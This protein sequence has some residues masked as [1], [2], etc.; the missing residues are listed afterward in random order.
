MEAYESSLDG[1]LGN[2][3]LIQDPTNKQK[4]TSFLNGQRDEFR[5]LVK[6][7]D[8]TKDRGV[9]DQMEAIKFSLVN[10]NDQIKVFD[11]DKMEYRTASN[12]N[13]LASIITY[14][15][16]GFFTNAFTNNAEMQ[17]G[18]NGD[19]GFI[20]NNKSYNYRDKAGKWN[21]N[22]NE[23]ETFV[24]KGFNNGIN[25]GS[26]GIKLNPDHVY[27]NMFAGLKRSTASDLQVLATTDFVGDNRS[28]TFQ[29]QFAS[30]DPKFK[31]IYDKI[32]IT[33]GKDGEYDTEW[34]FDNK[35]SRQ[36]K[37]AM[38]EYFKN[39][40]IDGNTTAYAD[41]TTKTNNNN[42]VFEFNVNQGYT[43][44]M[45]NGDDK[46]ISGQLAVAMQN[47][48]TNPE[49]GQVEKG[50]DGNNYKYDGGKFYKGEVVEK[51]GRTEVVYKNV[52]L[53]S[54]ISKNHG[55][56]QYGFKPEDTYSALPD[57][58]TKEAAAAAAAA[59]AEKANKNTGVPYPKRSITSSNFD[60]KSDSS[61]EVLDSLRETY[62]DYPGFKFENSSSSLLITAPDG[63]EKFITMDRYF[64]GN[65]TSRDEIQAF[66]AEYAKIEEK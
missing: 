56:W 39:V 46:Y 48:I 13:Q 3:N 7:F 25:N 6:I 8:K 26:K 15:R 65:K 12:E 9:R 49:E 60:S 30:G 4:I 40:V 64:R 16:D 44:A 38:A 35:N 27:T 43:M 11:E 24:L 29:E 37:T 50:Y 54:T 19:L 53:P 61:M 52:V 66:I 33:A 63:T 31:G 20:I 28:Q 55:L 5:R 18:E 1:L 59:D 36:L 58:S 34:M 22:A 62:K 47:F 41:Y 51:D 45:G 42:D 57:V 2:V 23:E 21:V 32:G 17:I 10:L 14:D